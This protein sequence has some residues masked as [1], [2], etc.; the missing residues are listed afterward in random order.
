MPAS[1]ANQARNH[2]QL[3]YRIIKIFSE[4]NRPTL[5]ST[6]LQ[7]FIG[8]ENPQIILSDILLCCSCPRWGSQVGREMYQ[9][10]EGQNLTLAAT[11]PL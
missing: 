4:W 3:F 9:I 6:L 11:G 10:D 5:L 8:Q 7:A 1:N 2:L